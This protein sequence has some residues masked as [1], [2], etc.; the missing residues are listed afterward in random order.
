MTRATVDDSTAGV[1]RTL[2]TGRPL[3]GGLSFH[4]VS[5]MCMSSRWHMDC[6]EEFRLNASKGRP[7][8]AWV[9]CSGVRTTTHRLST[10]TVFV[11]L[12]WRR[13]AGEPQGDEER[14]RPVQVQEERCTSMQAE[15]DQQA[16][17]DTSQGNT[18][19]QATGLTAVHSRRGSCTQ[20]AGTIF[21][22][23]QRSGA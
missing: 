1:G 18:V 16:T 23:E 12:G 7:T 3:V 22:R 2:R 20:R 6:Q 21:T 9:S 19:P 14:V 4:G 10:P 17:E 11:E 5:V 8:Q 13:H 15:N